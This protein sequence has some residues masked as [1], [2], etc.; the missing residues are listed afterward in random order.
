MR[1]LGAQTLIIVGL[2]VLFMTAAGSAYTEKK[3]PPSLQTVPFVDLNRYTGIWHEIARYPN[4]FLA[5]CVGC[6]A[7]Y[8]LRNDSRIAV[9]N[10]CYDG[11]FDGRL[12]SAR[13]SARIVDTSS[14][15]KLKVSLF[16]PLSGDYWIIDLGPDYEYA[17]IGHPKRTYLWILSRTNILERKVYED[18]LASLKEKQY[19]TTKLILPPQK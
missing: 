9:L 12:R 16:W 14:N 4:S 2:A 7:T 5:G 10:E 6:K 18:I 15:V 1:S 11:S 13:G 19:D 8:S 17:A 3:I